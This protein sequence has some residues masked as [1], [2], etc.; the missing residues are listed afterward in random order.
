MCAIAHG[1]IA[2]RGESSRRIRRAGPAYNRVPIWLPDSY[3]R[4]PARGFLAGRACYNRV[5]T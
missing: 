3:L 1:V 4:R 5:P 2:P